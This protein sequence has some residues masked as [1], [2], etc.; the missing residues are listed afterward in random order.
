MATYK[1]IMGSADLRT[2]LTFAVCHI[3][4]AYESFMKNLNS[5]N[6]TAL[7]KFSRNNLSF[8][9]IILFIL[10]QSNVLKMAIRNTQGNLS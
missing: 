2:E 6:I 4:C 8:N 7:S 10:K 5:I 1:D 9:E 3:D